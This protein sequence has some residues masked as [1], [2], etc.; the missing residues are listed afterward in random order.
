MSLDFSVTYFL[1]TVPWPWGWLSPWW[2][3]VPGTFLGVKAASAWGWQPHYLH[4]PNV[5]KS[6]SLNFLEPS[7]AHRACYGTPFPPKCEKLIQV[8]L[9]T[10]TNSL[11]GCNTI[12]YGWQVLTFKRKLLLSSCFFHLPEDGGSTRICKTQ[13]SCLSTRLYG[14]LSKTQQS[15]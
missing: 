3:W 7:G 12:Q 8:N 4:M 13:N 5:M 9:F 15:S 14:S 11:V 2:K 10:L 1:P 6:G